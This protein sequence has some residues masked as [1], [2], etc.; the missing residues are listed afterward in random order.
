LGFQSPGGGGLTTPQQHTQF[1]NYAQSYSA[2][3]G[4]FQHNQVSAQD[5]RANLL[6]CLLYVQRDGSGP[7]Y[8]PLGT[9]PTIFVTSAVGQ[10]FSPASDYVIGADT[11]TMFPYFAV[12]KVV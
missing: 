4:S 12:K 11:Y 8:S 5:G 6:P 3:P 10:G 9:V 1:P 2:T 7:G